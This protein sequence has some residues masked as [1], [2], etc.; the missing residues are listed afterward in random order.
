MKHVEIP[1]D[2][3]VKYSISCI[4]TRVYNNQPIEVSQALLWL[5]GDLRGH[6]WFVINTISM[7]FI[8]NKYNDLHSYLYKGTM[9]PL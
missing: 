2:I 3:I 4:L 5:R 6:A 8:T 9:E 1:A 7:R